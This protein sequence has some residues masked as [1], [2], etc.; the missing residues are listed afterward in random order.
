MKYWE[1]RY[2]YK[3]D[4]SK[5]LLW[6]VDLWEFFSCLQHNTTYSYNNLLVITFKF[7]TV[8]MSVAFNTRKGSVQICRLEFDPSACNMFRSHNIG[9]KMCLNLQLIRL[10][11]FSR[12]LK[13]IGAWDSKAGELSRLLAGKWKNRFVFAPKCP[14]RLWC[15]P[16]CLLKRT[17]GFFPGR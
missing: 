14:A 3:R 2:K 12:S 4:N 15:P 17:S 6:R 1:S 11:V 13:N 8:N 10:H 7:H 9:N 16:S 5:M